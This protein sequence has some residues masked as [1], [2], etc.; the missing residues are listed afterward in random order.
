MNELI[1]LF[2][3][4]LSFLHIASILLYTLCQDYSRCLAET[5]DFLV[6]LLE[7]GAAL[8]YELSDADQEPGKS[9]DKNSLRPVVLFKDFAKYKETCAE[10]IQEVENSIELTHYLPRATVCS[11][12]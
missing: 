7:E 3:L 6:R 12:F 1:F 9:I 2:L 10:R 4:P 5:K 8:M 11:N